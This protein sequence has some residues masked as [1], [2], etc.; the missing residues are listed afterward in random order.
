MRFWLAFGSFV[1]LLW[2]QL[3]F[4]FRAL[5][6]RCQSPSRRHAC[7]PQFGARSC[8][9]ALSVS[10]QLGYAAAG[11]EA[12]IASIGKRLPPGALFKAAL[13]L[14]RALAGVSLTPRGLA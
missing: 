3:F 9:Y 13:M 11:R 10:D 2:L 6:S 7:R 8:V 14:E 5:L 4:D 1:M 12:R